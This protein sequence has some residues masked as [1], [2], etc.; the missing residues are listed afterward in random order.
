M[1]CTIFISERERERE[2]EREGRGG[3]GRGRERFEDKISKIYMRS[4]IFIIAKN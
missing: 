1:R 4:T 2:R 3:R